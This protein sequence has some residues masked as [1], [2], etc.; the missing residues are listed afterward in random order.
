L[1]NEVGAIFTVNFF[2]WRK[3]HEIKCEVLNSNIEYVIPKKVS[4]DVPVLLRSRV[5]KRGKEAFSVIVESDPKR[6]IGI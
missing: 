3:I 1:K 6:I 4:E 5:T 2:Y